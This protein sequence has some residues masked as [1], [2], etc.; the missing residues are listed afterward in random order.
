MF[1]KD[2]FYLTIFH[3]SDYKEYHTDTTVRFTVT[4]S[5][6]KLGKAMEEGLHKTFKLTSSLSTN[7]MVCEDWIN[8]MEMYLLCSWSFA[9]KIVLY[10]VLQPLFIYCYYPLS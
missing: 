9:N 6:A 3:F 4:I 1:E 10:L 7:S 2:L 5:E 8:F